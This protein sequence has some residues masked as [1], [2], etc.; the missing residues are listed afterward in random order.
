MNVHEMFLSHSSPGFNLD[1]VERKVG[2][3]S[4]LGET[5]SRVIECLGMNLFL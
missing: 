2:L 5:L 3:L 1:V 4:R